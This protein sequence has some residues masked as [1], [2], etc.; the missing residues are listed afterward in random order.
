M[1]RTARGFIAIGPAFTG[2]RRLSSLRTRISDDPGPMQV[3][4]TDAAPPEGHSNEMPQSLPG[5]PRCAVRTGI[6]VQKSLRSSEARCP[7]ASR[8]Q[9]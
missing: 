6:A 3:V 1:T 8:R 7:R 9:T 2:L 4:S 5:A